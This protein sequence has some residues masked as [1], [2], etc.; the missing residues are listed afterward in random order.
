MTLLLMQVGAAVLKMAP[1]GRVKVSLEFAERLMP[2]K[3]T[4]RVTT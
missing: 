4:V 3:A 2:L 1:A